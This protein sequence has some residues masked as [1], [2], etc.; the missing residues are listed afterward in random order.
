MVPL[1][2]RSMVAAWLSM[3][4]APDKEARLSLSRAFLIERWD[5]A[6]RTQARHERERPFGGR[7]RRAHGLVATTNLR[8]GPK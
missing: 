8:A 4:L 6:S 3:G 5:H 2:R 7:D 1:K